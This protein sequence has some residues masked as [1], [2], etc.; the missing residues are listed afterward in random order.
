MTMRPYY[1]KDNM[2]KELL[3][4]VYT[5]VCGPMITQAC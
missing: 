5:N 1:T 3:E 4:L 2:T